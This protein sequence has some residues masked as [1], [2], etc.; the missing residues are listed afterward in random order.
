M[1]Y[2]AHGSRGALKNLIKRRKGKTC[3]T[4]PEVDVTI[5]SVAAKA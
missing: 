5:W 4:C 1:C 3:R 2:A